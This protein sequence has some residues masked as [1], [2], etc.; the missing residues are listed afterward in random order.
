MTFIPFARSFELLAM[1]TK[2]IFFSKGMEINQTRIVYGYMVLTSRRDNE[3][4]GDLD[5]I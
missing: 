1:F 5:H 4:F 3:V 2:S